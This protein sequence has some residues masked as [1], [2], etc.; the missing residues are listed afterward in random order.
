MRSDQSILDRAFRAK[1]K[2]A[3]RPRRQPFDEK[4]LC[5]IEHANNKLVGDYGEES[6]QGLMRSLK[7]LNKQTN[8]PVLELNQKQLEVAFERATVAFFS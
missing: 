6:G 7:P 3:A 5:F 4:P 1:K 8:D 2:P